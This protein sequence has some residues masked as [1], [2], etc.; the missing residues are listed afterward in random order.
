MTIVIT[1]A[2]RGLGYETALA[3]AADHSLTIVLAGHHMPRLNDAMQNIINK[4]GNGNLVA[5]P[6]DLSSLDSVRQ[7]TQQFKSASLPPLKVIICNAGISKPSVQERSADGYE[8]TFA[9]NHLGHFLLVHL[10]LDQLSPPARIVNVSS[11][12]HDMEQVSGPMQPPRYTRAEWFAYPDQ[13]PNILQDEVAAGGEAYANSKLCNVLFTYELDRRLQE[14]GLSTA[15]HPLT[16][17]AFDPGLMA[18]TGLG[19]DSQSFTRLMWYYVMP[20]MSRLFSFG[21]TTRQSGA[22]LA[23]LATAPELQTVSGRYY[24]GREAVQSSPDSYDRRKALDL[25]QTSIELCA[26]RPLDSPLL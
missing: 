5:M 20:L 19:R 3:L 10:L 4:S 1:G 12:A 17:N 14:A 15:E 13:D 9:I 21:K 22:D 7:F 16:S 8:L 18:G 2:S 25:W 23:Y 26:L 11:G 6:L 24:S